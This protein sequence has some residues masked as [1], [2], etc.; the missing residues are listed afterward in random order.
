[1]VTITPKGT[2]VLG[3]L[4][5]TDK[6]VRVLE[7]GSRSSKTWS[8][9]QWILFVYCV[10]NTGKRITITREKLTW[11]KSTVVKDFQ[12][13]VEMHNLPIQPEI[14][15]RRSEQDYKLWG[16]E[17][18]FIGIDESQKLFGRK[19]NITWCNEVIGEGGAS[20]ITK[21]QF[22]QLEMRTTEAMILD[23]NP[24]ATEHWIYDSI[25]TREDVF[26]HRSTML[27]N[28]FLEAKIRK[29]ILSYK[30]TP[31]NRKRGT[32]DELQWKIYGLGERADIKGLVF[33]DCNY[34]REMPE[35]YKWRCFG[36]DF[37]YTND[38]SALIEVRLSEGQ[39]YLREW[40][41]ETGLTNQDLANKM[42]L[43]GVTPNDE[44][45]ADSAEPK[46]IE[47]I[48]RL[49][50]WIKGA[51]KGPD[52]IRNGINRLKQYPLNITE[53]SLNLKSEKQHYRWAEDKQGK[54]VN[55]P[56]DN[57]NHAWDAI[58]YVALNKLTESEFFVL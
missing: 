55:K 39:L 21:K 23:Y 38:P 5:K 11:L 29:T 56:I 28:P 41:Y 37:G 52:S 51:E 33:P 4:Q 32:A 24:K 20:D 46:S 22:D 1:M 36:L 57:H 12:E 2:K 34:V 58:R 40:I 47:E 48:H 6:P 50:Y 45:I 8:I 54:A 18:S 10:K 3:E 31:E 26:H 25:L 13:I 43:L 14:N 17:I 16:N 35:D 19:Q 53:D 30:P 15:I 44:I 27:D 42:E 7:G 49:G 9:I